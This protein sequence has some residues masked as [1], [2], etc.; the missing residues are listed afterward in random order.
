VLFRPAGMQSR[1]LE[2][3]VNWFVAVCL[4]IRRFEP[5]VLKRPTGRGRL[6]ET[7][8]IIRGGIA[9]QMTSASQLR[10]T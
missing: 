6:E 4:S 1:T 7:V 8:A 9:M 3:A 2:T 5:G 10:T